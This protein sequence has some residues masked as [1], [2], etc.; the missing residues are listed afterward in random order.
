MAVTLTTCVPS[1]RILE[2]CHET[3]Q[4]V[5]LVHVRRVILLALIVMDAMPLAPL[6]VAAMLRSV[7]LLCK[8]PFKGVVIT[9]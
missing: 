6:A 4:E 1:D 9:T 3:E 8:E 2:P 7:A 5:V